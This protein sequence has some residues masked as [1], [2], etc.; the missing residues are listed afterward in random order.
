L[1]VCNSI[2]FIREVHFKLLHF[3][4]K[5]KPKGL[6][7]ALDLFLELIEIGKQNEAKNQ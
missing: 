3:D 5:I 2:I 6:A 1:A 4:W 7:A